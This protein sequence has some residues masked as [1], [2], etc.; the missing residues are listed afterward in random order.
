MPN[1]HC[2]TARHTI[3]ILTSQP[4]NKL[5]SLPH[6]PTRNTASDADGP[7]PPLNLPG[8]ISQT[9]ILSTSAKPGLA[10]SYYDKSDTNLSEVSFNSS[11]PADPADFP[12]AVDGAARDR[13]LF[14]TSSS[15][16]GSSK[17]EKYLRK[18]AQFFKKQVKKQIDKKINGGGRMVV[19]VVAFGRT[20]GIP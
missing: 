18:G 9:D 3:P 19:E 7:D 2:P 4:V 20:L 17:S 1:N 14:S 13:G 8:A 6:V 12:D 16:G 10:A 11:G 5:P 15:A